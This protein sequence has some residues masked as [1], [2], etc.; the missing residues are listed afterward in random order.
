MLHGAW[1]TVN[2]KLPLV[3]YAYLFQMA[4]LLDNA[5][6][7]DLTEATRVQW[8]L[9]QDTRQLDSNTQLQSTEQSETIIKDE[10]Q[11]S[12]KQSWAW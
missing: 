10:I 3:N 4:C 9:P 5:W 1:V 7:L 11:K 8:T 12:V 6:D 2:S